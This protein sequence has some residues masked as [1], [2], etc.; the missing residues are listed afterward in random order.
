MVA[1]SAMP[2]NDAPVRG[3]TERARATTRYVPTVQGPGLTQ[4]GPSA[5]Q[6]KNNPLVENGAPTLIHR[7]AAN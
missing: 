4:T 7:E 3:P 6:E 2:R 1:A 5:P